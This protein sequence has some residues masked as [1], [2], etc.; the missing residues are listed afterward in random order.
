MEMPQKNIDI[1]ST[2]K[3]AA[4]EHCSPEEQRR[5]SKLEKNTEL[6]NAYVTEAVYASADKAAW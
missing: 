3:P 6:F 4:L 5:R 1:V 2:A